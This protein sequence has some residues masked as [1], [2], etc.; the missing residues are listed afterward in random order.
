MPRISLVRSVR[1]VTLGCLVGAGVVLAAAAGLRAAERDAAPTSPPVK[2]LKAL[3]VTGGCCHD[4]ETQKRIL[5]EGIGAR[6]HIEWT[7]VHQGGSTTDTRIPLYENANWAEPF[8]VVVH[9]ECFAHVTDPA[10]T[11][12]ILRPHREGKP[13]VVIHCAM[14][15]YRDKTDEWFKFL[16]VTSHKHGKKYAFVVEN[17]DPQHPIMAAFGPAWQTKAGELYWITQLW[18][19]ARALGQAKNQETGADETCIWTNEYGDCRV[20][21]TTIGHHNEEMADPVFLDYVT[22]GILWACDKPAEAY[23][24]PFDPAK[25]KFA[26]ETPAATGGPQPTLAP[27]QP[28]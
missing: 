3:L 25:T 22:R 9:N 21:G 2:P 6:A 23:L 10:W 7:I 26:W 24:K 1:F 28:K 17:R 19:T 4:Y 12:R 5:S 15:C 13:A 27:P 20:F 14:H 8:D 11:E 16:G 18:P